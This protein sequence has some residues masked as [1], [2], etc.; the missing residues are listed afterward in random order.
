MTDSNRALS[1]YHHLI[2]AFIQE[3]HTLLSVEEL[4]AS[5][6]VFPIQLDEKLIGVVGMNIQL[7]PV[8][9][10]AIIRML[11]VEPVYR[12]RRAWPV[13]EQLF[14]RL[15]EEGFT[16]VEGWAYPRMS[17]WLG[18]SWGIT[19]KLYVY[20]EHLPRLR[21]KMAQLRPAAVSKTRKS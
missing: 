13:F 11:Y 5:M 15:L 9:K 7:T 8:G 21:Q 12:G 19:P 14:D 4:L 10:A 3:T 20:H 6:E 17:R 2:E 18:R 1:S 16:H